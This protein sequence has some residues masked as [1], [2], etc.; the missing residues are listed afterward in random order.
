MAEIEYNKFYTTDCIAM[1]HVQLHTDDSWSFGM[2]QIKL[3]KVRDS[4]LF[5]LAVEIFFI[6]YFKLKNF[7]IATAIFDLI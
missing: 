4:N 3:D 7:K 1:P 2:D 6:F 5:G